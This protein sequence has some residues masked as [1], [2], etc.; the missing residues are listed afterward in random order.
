MHTYRNEF[1]KGRP[2]TVG[3]KDE[4]G[5]HPIKRFSDE[6]D[7]VALVN[8]LNGGGSPLT[9]SENG[10]EEFKKDPDDE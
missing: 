3:F 6:R 8:Y 5:L 2:W 7:A 4:L 1:E 10:W 9:L